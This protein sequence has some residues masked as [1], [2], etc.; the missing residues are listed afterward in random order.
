MSEEPATYHVT[1]LDV[2]ALAK[3]VELL[4]DHCHESAKG[5]HWWPA[6]RTEDGPE[7]KFEMILAAALDA[8]AASDGYL[9]YK[10]QD[11][12]HELEAV[13]AVLAVRVLDAAKSL[14]LDL[15]GRFVEVVTTVPDEAYRNRYGVDEDALRRGRE[16]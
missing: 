4:Q 2:G 10:T 15:P 5:A 1:P 16:N 7:R 8:G 11:C 14:H 13:L 9:K 3:A 6:N 12:R